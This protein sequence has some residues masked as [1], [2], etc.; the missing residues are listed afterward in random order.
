MK[1]SALDFC[2]KHRNQVFCMAIIDKN[3]QLLYTFFVYSAKEPE[4]YQENA[5]RDT[6]GGSVHIDEQDPVISSFYHR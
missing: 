3:R 4:H 6:V 1:G 2:V 5:S